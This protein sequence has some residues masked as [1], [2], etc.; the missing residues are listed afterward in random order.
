MSKV[1][2]ILNNIYTDCQDSYDAQLKLQALSNDLSELS[3]LYKPGKNSTGPI[4]LKESV[5]TARTNQKESPN[6]Q[7]KIDKFKKA[8]QK[9]N[10]EAAKL[11]SFK[12]I[13]LKNEQDI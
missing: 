12:E 10:N 13:Y 8:L 1:N 2:K 9:F 11:E 6:D 5:Y 7:T 4:K 3:K